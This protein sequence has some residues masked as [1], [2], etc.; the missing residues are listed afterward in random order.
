M[1]NDDEPLWQRVVGQ[2]LTLAIMGGLTFA[3]LHEFGVIDPSLI[4]G[5]EAVPPAYS[6]GTSCVYNTR[7]NES[8]CAARCVEVYVQIDRAKEC[9]EGVHNASWN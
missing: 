4:D 2:G 8:W 5:V 9:F 6:A 1:G 7:G 3:V